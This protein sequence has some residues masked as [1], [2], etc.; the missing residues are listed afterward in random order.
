MPKEIVPENI[1]D[2]IKTCLDDIGIKPVSLKQRLTD[3]L[4]MDSL[5]V[6]ELIMG[7]EEI[8]GTPPI[9]DYDDKRLRTFTVGSVIELASIA[10]MRSYDPMLY[11]DEML[12]DST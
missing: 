4:K 2:A 11:N 9:I 12:N 5:E 6:A 3:D 10:Y 7:V 1:V 8:L